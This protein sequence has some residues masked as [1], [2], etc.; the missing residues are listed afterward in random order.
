MGKLHLMP[1]TG[2]YEYIHIMNPVSDTPD[3]SGLIGYIGDSKTASNSTLTVSVPGSGAGEYG[4]KPLVHTIER[5][6]SNVT[7][8]QDNGYVTIGVTGDG[9]TGSG[10]THFLGVINSSASLDSNGACWVN[11]DAMFADYTFRHVEVHVFNGAGEKVDPDIS[12][13]N[14]GQAV[15]VAF[16]SKEDYAQ[17]CSAGSTK[18][19]VHIEVA[20]AYAATVQAVAPNPKENISSDASTYAYEEQQRSGMTIA[21]RSNSDIK[22]TKEEVGG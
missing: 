18:M 19:Y 8:T 17:A 6:T 3:A 21:A 2:F 20:P 9:S 12:F 5:S 13:F 4:F 7:I 10:D 22:P 11:T 1:R 15:K 14:G 16:K